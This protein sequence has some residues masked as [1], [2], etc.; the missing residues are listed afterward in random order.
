MIVRQLTGLAVQKR[1]DGVSEIRT[2]NALTFCCCSLA[3]AI[4]I[5][6]ASTPDGH[7]P[8]REYTAEQALQ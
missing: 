7:N 2:M 8:V 3:I 1:W 5:S 4:S 6:L